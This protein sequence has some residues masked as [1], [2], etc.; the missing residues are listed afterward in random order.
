MTLWL[1]KSVW[2]Y[3]REIDNGT[4]ILYKTD[5]RKV[6]RKEK[7]IGYGINLVIN[8]PMIEF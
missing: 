5:N 3:A 6:Q 2:I 1:R 4:N 7:E 8:R